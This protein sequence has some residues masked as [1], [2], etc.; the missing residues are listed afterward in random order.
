MSGRG[1]GKT[2]TGAEWVIWNVLQGNMRRVALVAPTEGDA[3]DVMLQGD[4]LALDTP[5]PT[6][7]G[8]TTMGDLEVGEQV[9]DERGNPT[10]IVWAS[11]VSEGRPCY[12]V[13]FSDGTAIIAD[14]QHKW[15]T[16]TR[17]ARLAA[18]RSRNP[19]DKA[20]IVTTEE[21]GKTLIRH[22]WGNHAIAVS[23][24]LDYPHKH[25]PIHPY[26]LG[27]W[28]G[29]G[30]SKNGDFASAD[31]AIIE[32]MRDLGYAVSQHKQLYAWRIKGIDP[33]LRELGVVRNKHIPEMYLHGDVD[34]RLAL[35]QGL[36]D[37]DGTISEEGQCAFDGSNVILLQQ[38][39]ELVRSLGITC[40][41]LK[42]HAIHKKFPT[43]ETMYRLTFTTT[44]PVFVLP[45]KLA[46]IPTKAAPKS[47]WRMVTAVEPWE[48]VPVR[49]IAVDSNEHLYLAGVGGVPTHNSGILTR[50]PPWFMPRF[51]ASARRL[52]WPNGAIATTFSA[53]R[54][55]RLR[56]PQHDGAWCLTGETRIST[57]LGPV[58]LDVIL[59]GMQ[60]MTSRGYREVIAM[61]K[62]HDA[63]EVY[64]LMTTNGITIRGTAD[65]P[66]YVKH[67][68][69][70]PLG[71]LQRGDRLYTEDRTKYQVAVVSV[72]KLPFPKPVYNLYVEGQHE[73]FANGI[74]THNCD[75]LCSW[76]DFSTWDMLMFGLRLGAQPRCLIS[77]TPRPLKILKSITKDPATVVTTGSTYDNRANLAPSFFKQIV[78]KYEG[79][80]LGLQE[81][82]AKILEDVEGALWSYDIIRYAALNGYVAKPQGQRHQ[83]VAGQPAYDAGSALRNVATIMRDLR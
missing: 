66:F 55:D 6:P 9:F 56:G 72:I 59:P 65:H 70:I 77:T 12:R 26:V 48:S 29:D 30:R 75:E 16:H 38:T 68:G 19:E 79:T 39:L 1:A 51:N 20:A 23:G 73:Y 45:R 13:S 74:L 15:L 2:R 80:R 36:M 67:K 14:A 44:W 78:S 71:K 17:G 41:G 62:T 69:F 47:S 32:H 46:R 52:T 57:S 49:C 31:P 25:L 10:E 4:A 60:V 43:A 5:I 64:Q 82:H 24:P 53:E 58:G 83:P 37:T 35:L 54:P 27:A 21:M 34:Q 22:G 11:P 33:H 63:A 61:A 40:S 3:R 42:Q 28:L 81:L 8:W 7:Q 50:S 76:K 18:Q